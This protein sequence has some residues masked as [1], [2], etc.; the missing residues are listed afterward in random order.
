M[1]TSNAIRVGND[2]SIG[3]SSKS[4][5]SD[6]VAFQENTKAFPRG[7]GSN[8]TAGSMWKSEGALLLD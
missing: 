1:M 3:G 8:Q 2:V 6:N 5:E 4:L 7:M